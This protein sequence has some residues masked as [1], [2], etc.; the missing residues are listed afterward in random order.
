MF[1]ADA[2]GPKKAA[3]IAKYL[4][5]HNEFKSH[6]RRVGRK[7][8]QDRGATIV[9]LEK[10]PELHDRV[11]AVYFAIVHTFNGATFKMFENSRGDALYRAVQMI[12][13]PMQMQPGFPSPGLKIPQPKPSQSQP[14]QQLPP[15]QQP[16][17]A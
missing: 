11:L 17:Q 8:L 12:Q 7:A 13:I 16:P 9:D 2:N 15:K 4:G 14:Q 10:D 5:D 6:G 3:E 1:A